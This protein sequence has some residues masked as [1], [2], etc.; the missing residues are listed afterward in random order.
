MQNL[1]DHI[2]DCSCPCV[3]SGACTRAQEYVIA[4][5][6]LREGAV[7]IYGFFSSR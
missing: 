1:K 3:A 2:F 6:V 4:T 5:S 7:Y